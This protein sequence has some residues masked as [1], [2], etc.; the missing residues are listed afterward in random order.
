MKQGLLI[1]LSGPSGAGKGTVYNLVIDRLNVK[2]SISVTTRQPRVGE[3]NGVHYHFK[4]LEEYQQLIA[5]G[6]FLETA[7]VYSNYYG[8]LKK[9]VFAEMEKGN[10]VMFEIDINGASQIKKIY[11]DCVSIFIIPP[12]F[13]VL[14]QR[15]RDRNTDS[16][17]S[18]LRRLGSAKNELSKYK[19][20]DYIVFNDT[21]ED[22]VNKVV[23]IIE[24][25]RCKIVRNEEKIKE[26][27]K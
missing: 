17:E 1:V 14:E 25:E 11:P 24:S 2:K 18:I 3:E 22:S 23:S 20:F 5:N 6:E 7:S 15:L 4:S 10:D 26:L 12:S 19:K 16:Q 27:L 9:P 8:T 21:I 13:E